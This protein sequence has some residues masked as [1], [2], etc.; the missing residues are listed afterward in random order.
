MVNLCMTNEDNIMH[1]QM[2]VYPKP[3]YHKMAIGYCI[4]SAYTKSQFLDMLVRRFCDSL[5]EQEQER[6]RQSYEEADETERK[7]PSKKKYW[8]R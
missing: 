5:P 2:V 1:R 6:L 4:G 7:N 3:K 8:K